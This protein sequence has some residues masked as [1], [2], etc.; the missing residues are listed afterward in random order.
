V[1]EGVAKKDQDQVEN[2]DRLIGD[3]TAA[4]AG[5][6]EVRPLADLALELRRSLSP[7]AGEAARRARVWARLSPRLD[8]ARP[9]PRSGWWTAFRPAFALASL[10]IVLVLGLSATTAYASEGA[11]PGDALYPIKRGL[12]QAQLAVSAS[13]EGDAR[14]EARFA[15]QRV[16]E[17]EALAGLGRWDDLTSAVASYPDLVESLGA[18][19]P[20]DAE[21]QLNHHLEVLERVRSEAPAAAQAGLERALERAAKGRQDA[22][23]RRQGA[24][25][26]EE[27]TAQETQQ[28][29]RGPKKTPPGLERNG[30]EGN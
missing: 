10:A 28:P 4:G 25:P 7:A 5:A 18:L 19:D 27:P 21:V 8:S 17:I 26:T 6:H 3:L 20:A 12:E 16:G 11:L 2:L 1:D 30:G 24:K 23:H 22:E 15:D 29:E 14:L 13:S 9:A